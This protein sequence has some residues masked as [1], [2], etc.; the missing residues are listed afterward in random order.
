MK[1]YGSL[2]NR[3]MENSR[4]IPVVGMAATMTSYS[5]RHAGTVI[6]VIGK[7]SAIIVKVRQDNAKRIDNNGMS[8]SQEYEYSP[9]PD[10]SIEIFKSSSIGKPFTNV[11][12]NPVTG[13]LVKAERC[14]LSLG[15]RDE[16]FDFCF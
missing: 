5:D 16:H 14:G 3:L 6:E 1:F 9:N 4:Y 10:G 12:V 8:D 2:T 13:R 11:R 15:V 7:G